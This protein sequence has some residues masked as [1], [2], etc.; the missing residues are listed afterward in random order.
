MTAWAIFSR[1]YDISHKFQSIFFRVCLYMLCIKKSWISMY[2]KWNNFFP[3][4]PLST[5]P[6]PQPSQIAAIIVLNTFTDDMK[7]YPPWRANNF[8]GDWGVTVANFQQRQRSE[9][10]TFVLPI[11]P[12]SSVFCEDRA[13]DTSFPGVWGEENDE[14]TTCIPRIKD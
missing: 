2:I 11:A 14:N 3:V 6:P 9:Q 10:R 12:T 1:V 8:Q 7:I 5:S 13:T 4:F